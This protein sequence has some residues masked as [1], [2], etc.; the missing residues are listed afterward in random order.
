MRPARALSGRPIGAEFESWQR[1]CDGRI[2]LVTVAP[3]T[4]GALD[5][6]RR[7]TAAG[8]TVSIGHTDACAE[9]I[10]AAIAAGARLSTHLGNG[11]HAMLP[12][13]DNCVWEQLAADEVT[14]SIIVDGHHLPPAVVK[15]FYRVKGAGALVLISDA[16]PIAG[17]PP[18]RYPGFHGEVDLLPNGRIQMVGGPYLAGSGRNLLD[19]VNG[20]REMTGAGID[21]V[22]GMASLHPQR[23]LGLSGR[24]GWV[25]EGGPTT[26]SVVSEAAGR[27]RPEATILAGHVVWES[28]TFSSI[29]KGVC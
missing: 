3:E 17:L 18:G 28:K 16:S 29:S 21:E 26:F 25:A 23:M 14:A 7:A 13:L 20:M 15:C 24:T 9:K 6:I 12:R 19:C 8:V 10:R 1:L 2:R 11:S 5:F 4:E 27:L 22:V